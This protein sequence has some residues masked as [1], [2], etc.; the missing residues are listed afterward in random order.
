MIPSAYGIEEKEKKVVGVGL[1][2]IAL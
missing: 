2:S 1:G